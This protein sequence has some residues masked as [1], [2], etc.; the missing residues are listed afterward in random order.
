MVYYKKLFTIINNIMQELMYWINKNWQATIVDTTNPNWKTLYTT[1]SW[2]SF[3]TW[4]V[5][6]VKE[7]ITDP[8]IA[9]DEQLEAIIAEEIIEEEV[10]EVVEE[11]KEKITPIKKSRK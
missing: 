10:K 5:V 9:T 11:V 2:L 3:E 6:E 8:I 7:E 4:E 1:L